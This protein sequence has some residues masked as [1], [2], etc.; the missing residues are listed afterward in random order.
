MK[1]KQLLL[2]IGIIVLFLLPSLLLLLTALPQKKPSS[3][4]IP[5]NRVSSFPTQP[6]QQ[7]NGSMQPSLPTGNDNVHAVQPP[8][9][10]TNAPVNTPVSITFTQAITADNV[11]VT[12]DPA[13]PVSIHTTNNTVTV[14][15]QTTLRPATVYTFII[16]YNPNLPAYIYAFRTVGAQPGDTFDFPHQ[17]ADMND[18]I[19]RPDLYLARRTPYAGND[20]SVSSLLSDTT[21]LFSFTVTLTGADRQ[22]SQQDFLNW[23]ESQGLTA[24]QIQNL[25]ISYQ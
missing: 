10:S 14:T 23:A 18:I 7:S 12:T 16:R 17:R 1:N 6:A 24:Q 2:I 9:M 15:P 3:T 25:Q 22:Q 21:G 4:S 20:F 8:N 5:V 19:N 13:I 11:H